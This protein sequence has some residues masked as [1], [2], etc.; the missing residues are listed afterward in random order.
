[1]LEVTPSPGQSQL[2]TSQQGYGTYITPSPV[3]TL[4]DSIQN[5]NGRAPAQRKLVVSYH[6]IIY[7]SWPSSVRNKS[8]FFAWRWTLC[9]E[10]HA[11]SGWYGE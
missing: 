9:S 11:L 3:Q 4:F 7:H 2:N 1:M 6:L 5:D 10:M 8:S